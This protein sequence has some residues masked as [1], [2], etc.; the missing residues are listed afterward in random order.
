MR[1]SVA[2]SIDKMGSHVLF[3]QLLVDTAQAIIPYKDETQD[4]IKIVNEVR[5]FRKLVFHIFEFYLQMAYADFSYCLYII[6]Q[7][8]A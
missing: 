5:D 4:Q 2:G 7:I 8:V 1:I 3:N 6:D